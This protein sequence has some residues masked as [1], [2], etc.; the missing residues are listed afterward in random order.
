MQSKVKVGLIGAGGNMKARHIPGFRKLPEV[1]LVAVANRSRESG[2]RVAKEFGI[3]KVYDRWQELLQDPDIDAVCIGTWPYMHCEMT[4]AA[5]AA[6]KHVLC[7][8]RMAM[9]AK[10]A[11]VM[12]EASRKHPQLITQIVPG[13][14]TLEVDARIG[15]LLKEGYFGSLKAL[16]LS[17]ATG[18]SDP[19]APLHW[20]QNS[21]LS[22]LNILSMGIWYECIQRWLGQPESV[23]AMAETAVTQRKG[24]SGAPESVTVPDHVDI[25]A[26]FSKGVI[27]HM[28]FTAIAGL[29]PAPEVWLFGTEG[30]VRFDAGGKKLYGGRRGDKAL[31]E[32]VIPAEARVGW[33]VEEE[34][35]SAIQGKE[36]ITRTCFED[37]VRYMEFT[38]AVSQ[39]IKEGRAVPVRPL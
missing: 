37:G 35:V 1:E 26:R 28:R 5:L 4:L 36:K 19:N 2:Q 34:F 9:N 27:A 16:E 25:L 21:S 17:V 38:E 30:T 20:R 23:M 8:A 24:D 33:R 31:Q 39:S 6:G 7:E 13:P 29:A 32:I 22:G 15:E 14:P 3:A 18:F 12:L 10:E 11:R